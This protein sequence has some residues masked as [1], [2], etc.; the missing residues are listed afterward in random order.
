MAQDLS[1]VKAVVVG[2]GA[3]G[4][5]CLL[6]SYTTNSF[7]HKYVPT[8]FDNHS[9]AVALDG[10]YVS[11][12]LWD[13]AG[14]EDYDK[15]RPLSY[16]QTD[17]FICCFSV[18]SPTSFRNVQNKWWP[19]LHQHAKD[20]P[21]VLVGLKSDTRKDSHFAHRMRQQGLSYV[22]REEAELQ[23]TA[24]GASYHEC[25]ALTQEHLMETFQQVIREALVKQDKKRKPKKGFLKRMWR[26]CKRMDGQAKPEACAS[27]SVIVWQLRAIK[28][29]KVWYRS[30]IF[31]VVTR[32]SRGE[33]EDQRYEKHNLS[34]RRHWMQWSRL[35]VCT[36][37]TG[38][39]QEKK[40]KKQKTKQPN[41]IYSV[42]TEY[43]WRRLLS[44]HDSSWAGRPA[45]ASGAVSR[46]RAS[47]SASICTVPRPTP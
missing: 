22:S 40:Q 23:A 41:E 19:E 42:S 37:A 35:S 2:D 34:G 47:D 10:R 43:Y 4:K 21:I 31:T 12:G 30:L 36:M 9:C 15:L 25:S 46:P 17:V 7:P 16:P 33:A 11:L 27:Q 32:L 26:S 1:Q 14:Q 13:T 5:T 3:V 24:M 44:C 45:A 29:K 20:T 6:V 39:E 18:C 28:K 8:V 38:F